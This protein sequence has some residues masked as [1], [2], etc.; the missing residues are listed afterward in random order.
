MYFRKLSFLVLCL[1]LFL[2]VLPGGCGEDS[3]PSPLAQH[4]SALVGVPQDGYPNYQE[5]L[6]LV[7]INRA[8]ADPNV[9]GETKAACSTDYSARKPLMLSLV[10]SHCSRFHCANC[11]LNDGGLSHNSYCT[12]RSDIGDTF[13]SSCDGSASCSCEAGSEH[14]SCETLGGHGTSPWTRCGYF[15]YSA[16]G[17]VGSAGYSDGW[18]AVWGWISECSGQ[19]GHRRILTG[20]GNAIGLGF[21]TAPTTCWSTLYFGD[22]SGGGPSTYTLP[23]GVH[24]PK[25]GQSADFYLNV[26]DPGGAPE[27]VD[28]VLDGHCQSMQLEIGT[29]GQGTYKLH[30]DMGGGCHRYWF[31]V[32]DSSGQRA[33]WPQQGAWGAGDCDDY[34]L[35]AS[36]A[37]CEVCQ[38][39]EKKTCGVG[40]CAGNM[41]CTS[42]GSWSECDGPDPAPAENCD[43]VDNDCDGVLPANEQDADKDGVMSCNGDCDD[44]DAN[45][46]PGVADTCNGKDDDCDGLTDED[47]A[48]DGANSDGDGGAVDG[49]AVDGGAVDGSAADDGAADGSAGDGGSGD[50]HSTPGDS[51]PGK[52]SE[53]ILEGGCSCGQQLPYPVLL[54]WVWLLLLWRSYR[55]GI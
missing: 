28:L 1:A 32:R 19:D 51:G 37:D 10:G 40:Q 12:L 5:R 36:E 45:V 35:Y 39:G 46:H 6:M 22:L 41:T 23:A 33:A 21:F 7:A 55:N 4:S 43:G 29:Q 2:S 49:G 17:E 11:I 13:E 47:C 42:G 25:R 27:S 18:E 34:Q 20:A 30:V 3:A 15:G 52:E 48:P 53:L 9:E 50:D 44:G 24:Y 26:Y 38:A 54:P 16:N 31:L 14:F 8:R